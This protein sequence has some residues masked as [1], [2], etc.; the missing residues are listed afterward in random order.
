M[1]VEIRV[2]IGGTG[3]NKHDS[4]LLINSRAF[5]LG[6]LRG[7]RLRDRIH[8]GRELR[9]S[10][11][12]WGKCCPCSRYGL[13]R[14]GGSHTVSTK[15]EVTPDQAKDGEEDGPRRSSAIPLP[16]HLYSPQ[17]YSTSLPEIIS[18]K[19]EILCRSPGLLPEDEVIAN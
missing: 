12:N 10:S 15:Q 19:E 8:R 1:D 6:G 13:L 18:A 7:W 9:Y 4:G 16:E 3:R 5:A 14:R 2:R 11:G 17:N